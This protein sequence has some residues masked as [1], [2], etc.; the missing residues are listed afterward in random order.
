MGREFELK[1]Q[2]E[3]TTLEQIG[4]AFGPFREISMETT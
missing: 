3:E 4:A 2:A 1:Y